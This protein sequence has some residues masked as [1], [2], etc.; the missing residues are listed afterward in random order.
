VASKTPNPRQQLP[1]VLYEVMLLLTPLIE[2]D[3]N[4][5]KNLQPET[6]TPPMMAGA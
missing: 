4:G 1:G 6:K 2:K 5:L 3:K